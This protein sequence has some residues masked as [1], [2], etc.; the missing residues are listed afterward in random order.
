MTSLRKLTMQQIV[1]LPCLRCGRKKPHDRLLNFVAKDG[2]VTGVI[3]GDCQTT[4]EY[5]EAEVH[6]AMIDYS[7]MRTNPD[8]RR[9][10]LVRTL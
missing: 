10:Y 8:G 4:E 7:T 1:K 9:G 3:C 6:A 2:V 5:I